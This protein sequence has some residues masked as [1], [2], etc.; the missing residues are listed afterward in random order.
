M[1]LSYFSLLYFFKDFIYLFMS[2][3]ERERERERQR[4]RQREKQVLCK[5]PDVG[6][7]LGTLG[8]RPGLKADAQGVI[9]GSRDRVPHQA[10]CIEPASPSACVSGSL[11]VSLMNK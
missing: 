7:D 10:S 6:L 5:E 2:N 1:E 8:S 4:H 3:R 11:S 9:L